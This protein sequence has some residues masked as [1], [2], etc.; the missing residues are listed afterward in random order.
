MQNE[1][2]MR[3]NFEMRVILM[4]VYGDEWKMNAMPCKMRLRYGTKQSEGGIDEI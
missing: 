3:N 4:G 1:I 2:T